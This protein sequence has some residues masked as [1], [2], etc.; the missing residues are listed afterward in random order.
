MR[1]SQDGYECV[2]SC[3]SSGGRQLLPAAIA[4]LIARVITITAIG[5]IRTTATVRQIEPS[6]RVRAKSIRK[7]PSSPIT[8]V[9]PSSSLFFFIGSY[10]LG[11]GIQRGRSAYLVL[12]NTNAASDQE[13]H[14]GTASRAGRGALWA[15]GKTNLAPSGG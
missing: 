1:V 5:I 10:F 9:E 12:P 6:G 14:C 8:T 11:V 13:A 7:I 3:Y 15:P 2:G 4:D